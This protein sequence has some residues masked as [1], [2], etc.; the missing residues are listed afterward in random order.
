MKRFYKTR[1][2]FSEI[3]FKPGE[4][5]DLNVLDTHDLRYLNSG[6]FKANLH[7]HTQYS[8][9]TMTVSELLD[10]AEKLSEK[11]MIFLLQ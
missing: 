1:K 6:D 7:I 5:K 2:N 9:G 11:L 3:S 10:N 4:R 8:D